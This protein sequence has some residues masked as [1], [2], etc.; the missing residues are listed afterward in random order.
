MKTQENTGSYIFS[1]LLS[2][3][4]PDLQSAILLTVPTASS[5]KTPLLMFLLHCSLNINPWVFIFFILYCR[6]AFD[7]VWTCTPRLVTKQVCTL[8]PSEHR[9]SHEAERA[10]IRIRVMQSTI[11]NIQQAVREN[12][13]ISKWGPWS[14]CSRYL[15]GATILWC[16]T[17]EILGNF[18][19]YQFWH[20][21]TRHVSERESL[22][23]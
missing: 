13:S 2:L 22:V 9:S 19:Y 21:R 16:K 12:L 10:K 14:H 4:L 11:A 6:K 17:L 20:H 8:S 5:W 1:A 15:R 23:I 18:A 7:F 3:Y